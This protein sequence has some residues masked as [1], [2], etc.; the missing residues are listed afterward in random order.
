MAA[1]EEATE[2]FVLRRIGR[3]SVVVASYHHAIGPLFW[4]L[5]DGTRPMGLNHYGITSMM[6]HACRFPRGNVPF[7]VFLERIWQSNT[8]VDEVEVIHADG[9]VE[10]THVRGPSGD[11]VA[12]ADLAGESPQAIFEWMRTTAWIEIP[13]PPATFFLRRYD[14]CIGHRAEWTANLAEAH[15]FTA[16]QVSGEEKGHEIR[17]HGRLVP[18]AAA[19]NFSQR[20]VA[21]RDATNHALEA[22]AAWTLHRHGWGDARSF[23]KALQHAGTA[24]WI[25]AAADSDLVSGHIA[26]FPRLLDAFETGRALNAA[27]HS[28]RPNEE[29]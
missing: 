17:R 13:A 1:P 22:D 7:D 25:F 15:K 21:A 5:F 6:K 4:N 12:L 9:E 27:L 2:E 20:V 24:G 18:V 8:D 11:F 29:T 10:T 14:G 19:E 26:G 28:T 23:R 3:E 16:S